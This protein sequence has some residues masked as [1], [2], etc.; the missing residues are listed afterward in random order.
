M[1]LWGAPRELPPG[2]NIS[3]ILVPLSFRSAHCFP[4]IARI[5]V[6]FPTFSLRINL[7]MAPLFPRQNRHSFN[8]L[9]VVVFKGKMNLYV[10]HV[11]ACPYF[12]YLELELFTRT[13]FASQI[14]CLYLEPYYY[15]ASRLTIVEN[16]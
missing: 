14:V 4:Q 3:N 7:I 2:A 11:L 9:S 16:T 6:C 10:V 5:L 15:K 8:F 1:A 12:I 13:T